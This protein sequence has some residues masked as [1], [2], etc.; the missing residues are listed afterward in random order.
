MNP[1]LVVRTLLAA[2]LFGLNQT[3]VTTQS[4]VST[5]S[6]IILEATNVIHGLGH[7]VGK[8]LLIR[9]REDGTVEWEK[10]LDAYKREKHVSKI[11]AESMKSIRE[12]LN[13]IDQSSFAGNMG[14]YATYVD[15][16][17]ELKIHLASKEQV[18][19]FTVENPWPSRIRKPVPQPVQQLLC[20]LDRLRSSFVGEEL[21]AGCKDEPPPRK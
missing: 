16:W 18:K 20:E 14:P 3:P 17:V 1:N 2:L 15:T 10:D 6:P 4:N 19:D 5:K 8:T 13:E 9:L 11:S 12:R 21:E 7:Y